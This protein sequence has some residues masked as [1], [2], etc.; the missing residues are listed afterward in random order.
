MQL[1]K[2]QVDID[3]LLSRHPDHSIPHI[4][5]FVKSVHAD[6]RYKMLLAMAEREIEYSQPGEYPRMKSRGLLR[7]AVAGRAMAAWLARKMAIQQGLG[8]EAVLQRIYA[9]LRAEIL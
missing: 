1:S 3:A 2:G 4:N 5:D 6:P 7:D 9:A 8:I